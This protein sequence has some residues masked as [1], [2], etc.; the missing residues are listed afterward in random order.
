M[1]IMII[2]ISIDMDMFYLISFLVLP[3]CGA[4]MLNNLR[5]IIVRRSGKSIVRF[6]MIVIFMTQGTLLEWTWEPNG[7]GRICL[8]VLLTEELHPKLSRHHHHL[9]RAIV[10]SLACN[11]NDNGHVLLYMH[12]RSIHKNSKDEAIKINSQ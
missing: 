2:P 5:W 6:E 8:M 10:A 4:L 3:T 11:I 12:V 9:Y 7:C 1:E